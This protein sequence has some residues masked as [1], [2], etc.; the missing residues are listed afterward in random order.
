MKIAR[1]VVLFLAA[2]FLLPA[3]SANSPTDLT[4]D[5]A[6]PLE[7]SFNL[8][9]GEDDDD[10]EE[11]DCWETESGEIVCGGFLGSGS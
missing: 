6:V 4:L 10:E 11:E 1:L 9:D 5:E 3:C 8:D 2:A 7:A